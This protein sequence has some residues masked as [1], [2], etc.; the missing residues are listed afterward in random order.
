MAP[1]YICNWNREWGSHY[2]YGVAT[3]QP[4]YD[5]SRCILLWGFN[6]T[7]HGPPLPAR[8]SRA[9]PR[10]QIVIDPRKSAVAEKADLWLRVQPGADG[11]W[12]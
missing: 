11:A 10:R 3:P 1:V 12:R 4:D 6:L 2:T 7:L 8:I 5:N 9:K